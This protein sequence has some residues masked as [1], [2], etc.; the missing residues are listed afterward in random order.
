[1]DTHEI[2]FNLVEFYYNFG[3][4]SAEDVAYFVGYNA[5]SADD[6]K[7]ITGDDYVATDK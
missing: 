3:C 4:Y 2:M 1:M 5:I 7:E 6:Y